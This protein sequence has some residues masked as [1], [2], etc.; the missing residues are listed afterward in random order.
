MIKIPYGK[1]DFKTLIEEGYYYVDKTMYLEKMERV[2]DTLTYLRPRR[3]GKSLFTSML[4]YY[5]DIKSEYLYDSLFK[6]TYIYNNPTKNKNNYYVLKFDFSG[7]SNNNIEELEESFKRL[8][9]IS[10][11]EFINK[12]NLDIKVNINQ[13]VSDYI[14]EFLSLFTNLNLKNHIYVLIDEYDNFTNSIL[15]NDVEKFKNVTGNDS[16]LKNFY[17][18]LKKKT[19]D[20]IIEEIFITGVC[21]IT[22][23]S[24]TS[25]FNISTN[26]TNDYRFNSMIGL[27]HDEVRKIINSIENDISKQNGIY[28][29]MLEYYDGY[30]F[31]GELNDE[32][33]VFNAT[34]VMGFLNYYNNTKRYPDEMID[35]NIAT[36]YEKLENLLTINNN[37]YYIDIINDI[38]D[39]NQVTG[40]L[41]SNFDL[42]SEF[43]KN[44]I[45]SLLYYFGYLSIDSKSLFGI[46]FRMPNRVIT[47]LYIDYFKNILNKEVNLNNEIIESSIIEIIKEGKIDKISKYVSELLKLSENRIFKRFDEKYIQMMYFTLL[48]ITNDAYDIYNEYFANGGYT[49]LYIKSK[50]DLC[51]NDIMIEL[52]YIKKDD[53]K[54]NILEEKLNEGI[55]EINRYIEDKRI[56]TS[57][58]KK[59]VVVFVKDEIELLK[60]LD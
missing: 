25:G 34:L 31:N 33:K 48:S 27:T 26:I 58:L 8:V 9:I 38:L 42:G 10:V 1:S 17:A 36:G 46:I 60:E 19:A 39:N 2:A 30:L 52:K 5:Y 56:D 11:N 23:D 43:S 54:D 55:N 16:F 41:I 57:K 59:Y 15:N 18:E 28:N 53:Y 22:L 51:V 7:I 29:T 12:Y 35:S 50:T 13:N 21:S 6:N 37:N 44:H 47:D 4:Y 3:F 14:R 32:D 40:K 20:T 49:D 45:I 24:M